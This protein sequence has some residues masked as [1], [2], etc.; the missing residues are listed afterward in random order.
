MK[1][2]EEMMTMIKEKIVI[3]EKRIENEKQIIQRKFDKL[4]KD[5]NLDI[6]IDK[7]D[8]R[9]TIDIYER[10][11]ETLEIKLRGIDKKTKSSE[12]SITQLESFVE[13]LALAISNMEKK[14]HE[15]VVNPAVTQQTFNMA[16]LSWGNK[17]DK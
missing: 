3:F 11:K 10:F 8:K 13:N 17:C 16:C 14:S 15:M 4:A 12:K 2:D 7:V 1:N 6:L 5:M 9:L